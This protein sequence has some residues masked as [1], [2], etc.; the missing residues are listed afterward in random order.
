MTN[1]AIPCIVSCPDP[2]HTGEGSGDFCWLCL[3]SSPDPTH[4]AEKT[5]EGFL[6]V[7]NQQARDLHVRMRID[8]LS[9]CTETS[10]LCMSVS[11][12]STVNGQLSRISFRS[13]QEW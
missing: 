5:F 1:I 6:V 3:V 12:L 2:T 8:I 10:L 9:E 4:Y 7:L 13:G 11:T